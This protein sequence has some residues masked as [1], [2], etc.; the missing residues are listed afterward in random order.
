VKQ[1]DPITIDGNTGRIYEE[2]EPDDFEDSEIVKVQKGL[3]PE[4]HSAL[5][6]YYKTVL[7]WIELKE[8]EAASDTPSSAASWINLLALPG[9]MPLALSIAGIA[10]P[11][12]GLQG[13]IGPAFTAFIIHEAA[14]AVEAWLNGGRLQVG[15]RLWQGEG[16]S[17]TRSRG[18]TGVAAS[19]LGAA[20]GIPIFMAGLIDGGTFVLF[21][22]ASLML[23]GSIQD[24]KDITTGKRQ[25]FFRQAA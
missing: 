16:I 13:L 17:F 11:E 23:A 20:A 1:G 10:S 6:P 12:N 25:Q 4:G 9:V 8:R 15:R 5:Y 3:L 7:R 18:M 24:W 22:S 14:H 2:L 21:T 19:L